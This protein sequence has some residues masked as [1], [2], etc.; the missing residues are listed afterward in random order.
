MLQDHGNSTLRLPQSI[1]TSLTL[2]W[3]EHPTVHVN[4]PRN[5]RVL[6]LS[7][8]KCMEVYSKFWT[9][10]TTCSIAARSAFP[11][12]CSYGFSPLFLYWPFGIWHTPFFALLQV[13]VD[14]TSL[15]GSLPLFFSLS[16]SEAGYALLVLL[17]SF[18]LLLLPPCVLTFFLGLMPFLCFTCY[19]RGLFNSLLP[20]TY[21]CIF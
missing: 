5:P 6:T 14:R 8:L 7:P 1:W 16:I 2:E 9:P 3:K 20:C 17:C 19:A 13:E 21:L 11:P 12:F 10:S 15:I 4:E 18:F